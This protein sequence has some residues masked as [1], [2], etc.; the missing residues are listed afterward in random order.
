MVKTVADRVTVTHSQAF[1]RSCRHEVSSMFAASAGG[2]RRPVRCTGP[3]GRRRLRRSSL[4]I[5]PV[6]IDSPKRS[7]DE[8]LDLPLA[9]PVGPREHGQH[10]LQVRPEA[11]ARDA[12]GQGTAGRLSTGGAGQAME[13]IFVDDRLDLGQLGDLMDQGGRDRRPGVPDRSG[14]RRSACSRTSRGPSRAGP[15]RGGPCDA[16]VARPASSHWEER[17]ACASSRSDRTRGAWTSWWS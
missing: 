5:I 9:Q 11:A 3:P 2:P 12:R 16:R 7:A 10:G 13:P 4:E 14:D 1:F 17:G 8:L 6:E 15:R